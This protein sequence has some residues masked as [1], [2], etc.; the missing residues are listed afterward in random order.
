ML[1]DDFQPLY[2]QTDYVNYENLPIVICFTGIEIEGS[3]YVSDVSVPG[4]ES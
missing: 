1:A 2:E 4:K 3:S